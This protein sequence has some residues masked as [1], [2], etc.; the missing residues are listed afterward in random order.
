MP[1]N[2]HIHVCDVMTSCR[3]YDDNCNSLRFTLHKLSICEN[4][5][6]RS[7]RCP[8]DTN[9]LFVLKKTLNVQ[10]QLMDNSSSSDEDEEEEQINPTK[11]LVKE[12][13]MVV[14]G[15]EGEDE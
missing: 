9:N 6:C 3:Y 10:L 2:T 11:S 1:A 5:P 12:F 8:A 4:R 7:H 14:F 15:D 13:D